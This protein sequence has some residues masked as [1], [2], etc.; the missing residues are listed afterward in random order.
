MV[1]K[2]PLILILVLPLIA[3]IL[4]YWKRVRP[5]SLRFPSHDLLKG[6]PRSWKVKVAPLPKA[7]RLLAVILFVVALAG[8]RTVLDEEKYKAEGVDIIL[9]MDVSRSLASE[10]FMLRGK[11]YNRLEVIKDVVKD[12]I[13]GRQ[14]DRIGIVAFA[15]LAYTVS[16]L[17][18]DY[19][20]LKENLKR[21]E[22]DMIEDGTA[23]GSGL[24]SSLAR[25]KSSQAKSK[26]VI[27]LTDGVNNVG[28]VAP[29]TAAQ[30]A[31]SLG[32]RVYTIGAGTK[33]VVPYPV[34]DFFGNTHYQQIKTDV[35]EET[36]QEIARITG[37][38]YFRATDTA[39]LRQVYAEIDRLEKSEFE[40]Q[41]YRDYFEL[42][43]F[44]LAAGLALLGLEFLLSQTILLRIP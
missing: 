15:G 22:F 31:K 5:P 27:L 25:L 32:I 14:N 44:F 41:G 34:K 6:I 23:I 16:P 2:D 24:T 17:T 18:K 7:L 33:G 13:D 35:D 37:A 39:E 29:L 11:R 43:P 42:F 38:K 36:L 8:P 26:V 19:A 40:E 12:F 21:I 4:F 1:F 20:W 3:A 30:A 10:D 28:R 9:A